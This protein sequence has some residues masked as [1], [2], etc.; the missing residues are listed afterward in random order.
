VL[1]QDQCGIQRSEDDDGD[2][3]VLQPNIKFA[4]HQEQSLFYDHIPDDHL[5]DYHDV[6]VGNGSPEELADAIEGL[7]TSAEQTGMS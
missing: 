6:I 5:I 4:S 2:R 3:D 7:S 1:D